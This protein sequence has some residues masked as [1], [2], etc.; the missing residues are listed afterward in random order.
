MQGPVACADLIGTWQSDYFFEMDI[1][2][3]QSQIYLATMSASAVA[4]T[5]DHRR[6]L[7]AYPMY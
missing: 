2:C 3:E 7:T 5:L 6:C 1:A 4:R